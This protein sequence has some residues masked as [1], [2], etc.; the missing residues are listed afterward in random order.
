MGEIT[1]DFQYIH[2]VQPLTSM[3]IGGEL[4]DAQYLYQLLNNDDVIVADGRY[5]DYELTVMLKGSQKAYLNNELIIYEPEVYLKHKSEFSFDRKCWLTL[6]IFKEG[7]ELY[8]RDDV[9]YSNTIKAL[10]QMGKDIVDRLT[11]SNK[12]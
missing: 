9:T 6:H 11:D 12:G 8:Q 2:L 1:E 4:D 5:K 10:L 7:R 3:D